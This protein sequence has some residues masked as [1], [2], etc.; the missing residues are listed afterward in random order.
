[1]WSSHTN[2]IKFDFPINLS[3]SDLL[4]EQVKEPNSAILKKYVYINKTHEEDQHTYSESERVISIDL[5]VVSIRA[6]NLHVFIQ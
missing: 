5:L 4:L 6:E 1:M 2:E 3:H